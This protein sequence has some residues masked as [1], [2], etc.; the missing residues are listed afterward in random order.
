MDATAASV[1]LIADKT[2][3]EN[4]LLKGLRLILVFPIIF[5]SLFLSF[6]L[7]LSLSFLVLFI[8]CYP[9]ETFLVL[10][11]STFVFFFFFGFFRNLSLNWL[12]RCNKL[13]FAWVPWIYYE[14]QQYI[15]VMWLIFYGWITST[16]NN[17][18]EQQLHK[19]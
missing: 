6:F 15:L 3:K 18:L 9:F 13:C 5:F 2:V 10:H 19:N 16:N 14:H 17:T 4:N 7:S 11:I 8:Y 12:P 1:G